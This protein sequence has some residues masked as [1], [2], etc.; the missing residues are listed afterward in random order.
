MNRIAF[1][2]LTTPIRVIDAHTVVC[3]V[4]LGFG[5]TRRSRMQ[6]LDPPEVEYG[7]RDSACMTLA[8]LLH[9][10]TPT[11]WVAYTRGSAPPTRQVIVSPE[12]PDAYTR[13]YV[14]IY[15]QCERADDIYPRSLCPRLGENVWMSVNA[16][17]HWCAERRFD[18]SAVNEIVSALRPRNTLSLAI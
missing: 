12:R 11:S 9:V 14:T 3:V 16:V 6:L 7:L 10:S 2:Y 4:D 15:V 5:I 1:N 8:T 13:A 17:M 18:P